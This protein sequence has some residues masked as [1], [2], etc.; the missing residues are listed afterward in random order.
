MEEKTGFFVRPQSKTALNKFKGRM[1][2]IRTDDEFEM[3]R[4]SH[5]QTIIHSMAINPDQWDKFCEININW[6]GDSA[7][8]WVDKPSIRS[9]PS[10]VYQPSLHDAYSHE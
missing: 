2:A 6:I 8:G 3:A 9:R 10:W 7:V 4:N 1:D 5:I